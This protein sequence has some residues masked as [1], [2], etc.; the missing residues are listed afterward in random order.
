MIWAVF[1]L[2]SMSFDLFVQ[3][4][5]GK[6]IYRE[7]AIVRIGSGGYLDKVL[8]AANMERAFAALDGMM[9][10]ARQQGATCF[11]AIATGVF[12][13]AR[14]TPEF[15]EEVQSRLGLPIRMVSGRDEALI[16]FK[17]VRSSQRRYIPLFI[18][19]GGASTEVVVREEAVFSLPLGA[20]LLLG[21]FFSSG[22]HLNEFKNTLAYCREIISKYCD[23]ESIPDERN[24]VAAGSTARVGQA[25]IERLLPGQEASRENLASILNLIAGVP[26]KMRPTLGI[27]DEYV[28]VVVP[29]LA[30]LLE[31]MCFYRLNRFEAVTTSTVNGVKDWWVL[32]E[33]KI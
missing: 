15:L 28:E 23:S 30:I 25:L 26:P 24:L 17:A 13:E 9:N 22:D 3:A 1:K 8:P 29:G 4:D 7:K 11:C 21:T 16:T 2:G 27:P 12:R 20:D 31:C 6:E 32:V 10:R 33:D 14:N 5:D 18:D 19:I